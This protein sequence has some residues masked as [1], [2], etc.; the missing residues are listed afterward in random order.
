M[1]TRGINPKTASKISKIAASKT[2]D[3]EKWK[4]QH[5]RG[6]KLPEQVIYKTSPTI[7]RQKTLD[8]AFDKGHPIPT[9]GPGLKREEVDKTNSAWSM[10]NI[11]LYSRC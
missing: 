10:K 3:F 8:K 1:R 7:K 4:M 6:G 5:M 9:P 11:L 2:G